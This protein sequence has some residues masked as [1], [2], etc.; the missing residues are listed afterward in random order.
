MGES[1]VFGTNDNRGSG[2]LARPEEPGP[3]VVVIQEWWGLVDHIKDVCDRLAA[4]GFVAL[5]PDLYHGDSASLKEPD[6]A[7]KLLMG[8]QLEQAGAEMA[9]AVKYLQAH[10][11]V[12]PKK[13]G[14]VGFCMGG[15]LAL[16]LGSIEPVDAIVAYY[17]YPFTEVDLSKIGGAVLG[18]IGEHDQAPNPDAAEAM[19]THLRS[20]GVEAEYHVYPGA[21]HAFFNDTRSDTYNADAATL[22]WERTLAFLR[23]HLA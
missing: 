9:G 21:D 23:E 16:Y 2:Y 13:V 18:H 4:E 12:A 15:T 17:P 6:K 22:S 10:D 11:Q 14:T 3:A 19:F 8:M 20:I 5:A 1:V 7:G